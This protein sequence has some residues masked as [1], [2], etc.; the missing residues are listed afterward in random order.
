MDRPCWRSGRP[1][2]RRPWPV[3]PAR[4]DRSWAKL[5][6]GAAPVEQDG[7]MN[8]TILLFDGLT[9]LDAVGP[10]EVLWRVP[11]VHL[12]FV[13]AE[14]GIKRSDNGGLLGLEASRA[15]ADV[16]ATDVLVVPGG[17]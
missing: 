5:V 7:G 16:T 14:A 4:R 11:G 2:A 17:F 3:R 9:A 8:V 13:A 15:L 1:G 10:Y 6:A 12:E